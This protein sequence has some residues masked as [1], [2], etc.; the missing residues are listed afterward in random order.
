MI[1]QFHNSDGGP[2]Q[3][4]VPIKAGAN[5]NDWPRFDNYEFDNLM[6]VQ[7]AEWNSVLSQLYTAMELQVSLITQAIARSESVD[8]RR[9]M[10]ADRGIFQAYSLHYKELAKAMSRAQTAKQEEMRHG[11]HG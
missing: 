9:V 6:P 10:R 3:V 1:K 4:I 7:A 11:I 5:I 8:Q 2:K